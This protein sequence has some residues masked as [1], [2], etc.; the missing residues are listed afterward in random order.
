MISLLLPSRGRPTSVDR[1]IASARATAHAPENLE[2]VIR[3]D[4]DD[5]TTVHPHL[6]Q[7]REQSSVKLLTGPRTTLSAYWNECWRVARGPIFAQMG[8]DIVFRTQNWDQ[9]VLDAFDAVPDKI[10]LVHGD[11]GGSNG[12]NFATH[13]FLHRHWTD[14]LGYFTAPYFSSDFGDSWLMD[15]A[16]RVGRRRYIEM[17]TDHLHPVHG[18]GEW[19]QTHQ[20]R[21]ARHS[22]DRPQD[23]F[24]QK[25]PERVR[26]AIKLHNVIQLGVGVVP[27][28]WSILIATVRLRR[29]LLDR[30]LTRLLP[31]LPT[32]GTVEVVLYEDDFQTL[33][34]DKRN[35]LLDAARGRYCN[36][37]DDDDLVPEYYVT[38][39]LAALQSWPD[40]VGWRMQLYIDE[41]AQKPTFHSLK[42]TGWSDDGDGYYRRISHLNPIL[43]G[44]ARL[45][46]FYYHAGEG[47][48]VMWQRR[49]DALG[50]VRTESYIPEVMYEYWHS[51]ADSLWR[52]SNAPTGREFQPFPAHPALRVI[53]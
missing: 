50:I 30:L 37:I 42:Y 9:M 19:D 43:T 34:A 12:K 27:P 32:D 26:D 3:L 21:L 45:G 18:K 48:D 40:Y 33:G 17:L 5:P 46:R 52:H 14:T 6:T 35:A 22:A 44:I 51:P 1:L 47:D 11:D 20:E 23:L 49:V 10:A 38:K 53:G 41:V 31:Q 7:Y 4:D 8:D 2:F 16:E 13:G 15:L 25:T 28:I 24:E 39:V 36:F 29:R